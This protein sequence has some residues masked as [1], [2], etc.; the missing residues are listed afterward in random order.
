[1]IIKNY[2]PFKGLDKLNNDLSDKTGTLIDSRNVTIDKEKLHLRKRKG[3]TYNRLKTGNSRL[4][5]LY[6]YNNNIYTNEI[7]SGNLFFSKINGDTLED[8]NIG[9]I[10]NISETFNQGTVSYVNYNNSLYMCNGGIHKFD[11]N[12]V[13]LAGAPSCYPINITTYTTGGSGLTA[14]YYTL[15]TELA[16]ADSTGVFSVGQNSY[17]NLTP[18]DILDVSSDE[19][20]YFYLEIPSVDKYKYCGGRTSTT[21]SSNAASFTLNFPSHNI[22]S[23]DYVFLLTQ[24]GIG[25]SGREIPSTWRTFKVT[26]RTATSITVDNPSRYSMFIQ[27]NMP[28]SNILCSVWFSY[29]SSSP[30]EFPVDFKEVRYLGDSCFSFNFNRKNNSFPVILNTSTLV[31]N[32]LCISQDAFTG[33]FYGSVEDSKL[34]PPDCKFITEYQGLMICANGFYV[35]TNRTIKY[36]A[37]SIDSPYTLYWSSAIDSFET[38]SLG[39]SIIIGDS[40][41]GEIT[42]LFTLNDYLIIFKERSIYMLSGV[43]ATGNFNLQKVDT[44]VGHIKYTAYNNGVSD[45]VYYHSDIVGAENTVY[46]FSSDGLYSYAPG[47][48]VPIMVSYPIRKEIRLLISNSKCISGDYDYNDKKIIWRFNTLTAGIYTLE[49]DIEAGALWLHDAPQGDLGLAFDGDGFIGLQGKW[50]TNASSESCE[51]VVENNL[52]YDEVSAYPAALADTAINAMARFSWQSLDVNN[53]AKKFKRIYLYALTAT[54]TA[55]NYTLKVYKNWITSS[56]TTDEVFTLP[57]NETVFE[58]KLTGGEAKQF[59]C[60][61]EISNN[62]LTDMP[63]SGYDLEVETIYTNSKTFGNK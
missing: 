16:I 6:K 7:I 57:V 15:L 60:S 51:I 14:G 20:I 22:Q 25:M 37:V 26:G 58:K 31:T 35:E 45:I 62:E 63:I 23:G 43:L 21:Y 19:G 27:A 8:A 46:F 32:K 33:P 39:N 55:I 50:V 1:M 3:V 38:F 61:I 13:Q 30:A 2:A 24:E 47:N 59:S 40:Q 36:D 56:T 34:S 48:A 17:K 12:S 42:G 10:A 28:V 52:K 29:R 18:A 49:F 41:E 54:T 5:G 53:I 11:G 9:S 44:S 4:T